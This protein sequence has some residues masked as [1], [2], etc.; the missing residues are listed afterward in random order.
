MSFLPWKND[1]IDR[2]PPD[3]NRPPPLPPPYG[4]GICKKNVGNLC[5]R[6]NMGGIKREE[7]LSNL[8]NLCDV[9]KKWE[10]NVVLT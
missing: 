3:N 6:E 7:S 5:V 1:F 10:P 8:M 2:T 9:V 4:R